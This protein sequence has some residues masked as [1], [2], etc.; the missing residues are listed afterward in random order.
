MR[1]ITEPEVAWILKLHSHGQSA[2]DI[3]RIVGVSAGA[4]RG[5]LRRHECFRPAKSPLSQTPILPKHPRA[6]ERLD[7]IP[8]ANPSMGLFC[9]YPVVNALSVAL[10][11]ALGPSND[12]KDDPE[13]IEAIVWHLRNCLKALAAKRHLR[14]KEA[15]EKRS[16]V[17]KQL[18]A[19][20]KK[21]PRRGG[22]FDLTFAAPF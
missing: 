2:P 9:S 22:R 8:Q 16:R 13:A 18:E 6:V 14:I 19:A 10:D 17:R 15:A 21:G 5:I 12:E 7:P 4:V 20:A 11:T 1:R 3:V